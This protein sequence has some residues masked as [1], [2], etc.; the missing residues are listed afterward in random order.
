MNASTIA[1]MFSINN[2]NPYVWEWVSAKGYTNHI[3][4]QMNIYSVRKIFTDYDDM[5]RYANEWND[6]VRRSQNG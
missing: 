6:K 4:E 3:R 2:P 1:T 5:K